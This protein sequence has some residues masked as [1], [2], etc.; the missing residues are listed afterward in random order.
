MVEQVIG[1]AFLGAAPYHLKPFIGFHQQCTAA[2]LIVLAEQLGHG[3]AQHVAKTAEVVE[4]G[5]HLC[6]FDLAQHALAD[7]GNARYVG[8]F[9]LLSLALAFD[10]NTQ[11]LLK[12]QFRMRFGRH[13]HRLRTV[14]VQ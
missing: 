4:T 8:K 10:L 5:R 12:L 11:V 3:H 7:T 13:I 9:Q 2:L 14:S 6:I 1:V